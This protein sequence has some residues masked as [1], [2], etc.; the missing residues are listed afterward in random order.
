MRGTNELLKLPSISI[1][2]SIHIPNWTK[3][4]STPT[5][6]IYLHV[7]HSPSQTSI[8]VSPAFLPSFNH[9]HTLQSQ[10]GIATTLKQ[11]SQKCTITTNHSPSLISSRLRN[12]VE[13][14]NTQ[15]QNQL[16]SASQR[17]DSNLLSRPPNAIFNIHHKQCKHQHPSTTTQAGGSKS[18]PP[19][20]VIIKAKQTIL[21]T[22]KFYNSKLF[23]SFLLTTKLLLISN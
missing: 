14:I 7:H 3:D 22:D 16:N 10:R 1:I 8:H 15:L 23:I 19:S 6:N 18:H 12:C 2:R 9:I 20:F 4:H 17:L 13:N 11:K 5:T 21:P